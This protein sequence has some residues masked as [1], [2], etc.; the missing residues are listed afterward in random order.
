MEYVT[1]YELAAGAPPHEVWWGGGALLMAAGVVGA[2]RALRRGRAPGAARLLAAMGL[3]CALLGGLLPMWDQ[4]RLQA[5]LDEGRARVAEGPVSGHVV[6]VVARRRP[7]KDATK[8]DRRTW[9]AFN[10]GTTP[11]GYYRNAGAVGFRNGGGEQ[12]FA[13]GQ[14]LRVHYVEDEPGDFA[15]R[16]IVR[17]ERA[18]APPPDRHAAQAATHRNN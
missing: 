15:Q 10:V 9:E 5:A 12:A 6:E 2:R 11:F 7:G 16:R 8:V 1:V 17:L 4:A 13:D 3:L 18:A 14:W